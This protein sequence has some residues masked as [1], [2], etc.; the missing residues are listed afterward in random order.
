MSGNGRPKTFIPVSDIKRLRS[1]IRVGDFVKVPLRSDDREYEKWYPYEENCRIIQKHR[2]HCVVTHN[3][4][5]CESVQ[6]IDILANLGGVKLIRR[7][8]HVQKL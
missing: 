7:K 4:L 5:Y 3:G 8:N 2:W 6:Y 1:Q